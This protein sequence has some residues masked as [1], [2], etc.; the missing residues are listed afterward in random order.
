MSAATIHPTALVSPSAE[1][2][3]GV[4]IGPFSIVDSG[5]VLGDGTRV[6]AFARV[7]GFVHIGRNCHIFENVILG[8][9]PQD[10]DFGGE[11]SYVSIADDVVMREN[12]TIHRA[13]GEGNETSVG[14]GTLLME[15]CHLGHNVRIGSHCTITNKVGFSGHVQIGDHVVVGGLTGFHQFVRVGSY[16]M[17]GGMAKIIKDVPPYSMVDGVPARVRGLNTL[18]LKR[19]GFT[20]EERNRIKD[21]YKLLYRG[22]MR[23][24]EAM[25]ALE[26]R[27]A[28]DKFADEILSFVRSL[29]RGLTKW[30]E[31]PGAEDQE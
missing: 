3:E 27:Y 1:L 14:R 2:G 22:H 26:E 5:A 16:A 30:I 9:P 20:Q 18:G 13:T 19:G 31:T 7:G 12:V 25:A 6:E 17:V 28:S 11:I 21:I 10:H 15:G 8:G 23:R 24:S 4:E 29:R